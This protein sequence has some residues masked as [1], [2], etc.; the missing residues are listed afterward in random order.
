MDS[1]EAAL[2]ARAQQLEA[3]QAASLETHR[4]K[5][6]VLQAAEDKARAERKELQ[7]IANEAAMKRRIDEQAA[8]EKRRRD[9]L[10]RRSSEENANNLRQ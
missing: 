6:S 10:E 5:M 7:R 2:K 9:D 4:K 3:D 8:E 1:I